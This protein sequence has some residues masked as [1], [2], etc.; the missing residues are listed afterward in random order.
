MAEPKDTS[1]EFSD[2]HP[3]D[4]GPAMDDLKIWF[5]REVLPLEASLMQ[6]LRQ[7]WRQGE[8]IAD[9]RQDIYVRVYEAAQKQIPHPAKPFVFAIARN[10]LIDRFRRARIIPIDG[11]A[12]LEEVDLP[13][14]APGPDRSMIA[15]EELRRLRV[16]L[17]R[18]PT[19]CREAVILRRVEKLSRR[20]IAQRMGIAENTVKRHLSDAAC[21]LADMLY[22]E[23]REQ[24][25]KS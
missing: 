22:G 16:A 24:D 12:D 19:R 25:T 14:D 18:L 11:V 2:P 8:D 17:N 4:A 10:L 13:S 23:T 3:Q 6:F 15:R 20:E 21:M 9:L 7:S 1:R 5:A